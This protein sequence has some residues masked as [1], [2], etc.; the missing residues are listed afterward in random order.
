MG[1]QA[2][3]TMPCLASSLHVGLREVRMQLDL[4]DGGHDQVPAS[5]RSGV[6]A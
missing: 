6:L 3:V 4:V 5:S 2:W 1:D